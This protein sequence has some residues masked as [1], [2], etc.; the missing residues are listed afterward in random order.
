MRICLISRE[1]PPETGWGGIATFVHDLALGL[2]EIGQEVEV[3]ALSDTDQES[4]TENM[5]A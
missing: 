1:F 2:H 4:E 5:K 3:I